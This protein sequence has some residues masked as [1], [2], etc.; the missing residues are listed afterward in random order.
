MVG[1]GVGTV[2]SARTTETHSTVGTLVIAVFDAGTKEVVWHGSGSDTLVGGDANDTYRF[3]LADFAD[4]AQDTIVE[5]STA[6]A[7]DR[8]AQVTVRASTTLGRRVAQMA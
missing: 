7:G 6:K 8:D 2:G 3:E 1:G 4:G 5:E